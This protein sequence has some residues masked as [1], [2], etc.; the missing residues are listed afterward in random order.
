VT[1]DDGTDNITYTYSFTVLQ[2]NPVVSTTSPANNSID[3]LRNTTVSITVLDYQGDSMDI[4][5]SSNASGSWVDFG[6]NSSVGNGTY[7]QRFVNA[8][9]YD[10]RYWWSVD[11]NGSWTNETYTFTTVITTA[12]V[13]TDPIPRN[14]K[15]WISIYITNLSVVISDSDSL[16]NYTIETNP[17]IGSSGNN[18]ESD[19]IKGCAVSGLN[20]STTYTW[21]VNATDGE[22]WTNETYT[23][24]TKGESDFDLPDFM[25][26]LPEF[27]VGPFKVYVNDF[28]WVFIFIGMVGLVWG[29]TKN[30]GSTL[31]ATLLV[32]AAYG[33]KRAFVDGMGQQVSLMFSVI[34]AICLAVL[35][36]GL[37]LKKRHG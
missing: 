2:N 18:S 26:N 6:Y 32:F 24:T 23:F 35:I 21:H 7:S 17:D 22:S 12:P 37:F 34:A 20:Y 15:R 30:V 19:G 33:G 16:F 10:T 13:I 4:A 5:W 28:V 3:V 27:A 25:E 31:I 36:L 14:G 1:V 8:T 11:I 9:E 29:A